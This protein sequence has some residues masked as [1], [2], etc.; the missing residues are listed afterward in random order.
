M[1]LT[2]NQNADN[3]GEPLQIGTKPGET[4]SLIEEIGQS[5]VATSPA[6]VESEGVL[7]RDHDA[8][9]EEQAPIPI[10]TSG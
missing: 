9:R 4:Q 3:Q 1:S 8:N 6:Q 10:I 7:E 5:G 2:E